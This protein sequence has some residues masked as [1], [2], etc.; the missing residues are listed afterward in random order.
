MLT[1][2]VSRFFVCKKKNVSIVIYCYLISCEFYNLFA[3]AIP[4][5]GL[6]FLI[7]PK[8]FNSKITNR[9]RLLKIK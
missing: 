3:F 6:F 1:V 8:F 4:K 9:C 2:S 5:R 7:L